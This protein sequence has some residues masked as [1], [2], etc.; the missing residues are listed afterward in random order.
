MGEVALL[1]EKFEKIAGIL[2]IN[3]LEDSIR[4]EVIDTVNIIQTEFRAD[5][6][7]NN[8]EATKNMIMKMDY[9]MTIC[10]DVKNDKISIMRATTDLRN[11]R[12][13][14]KS[15]D[16]FPRPNTLFGY[17]L[18]SG[19]LIMWQLQALFVTIMQFVTFLASKTTTIGS[20]MI[21]GAGTETYRR[22]LIGE[23]ATSSVGKII[24]L[25]KHITSIDSTSTISDIYNS[26]T[27]VISPRHLSESYNEIGKVFFDV[28]KDVL[29]NA[30]P[31]EPSIGWTIFNKIVDSA[32]VGVQSAKVL[33]Y[34]R[35]DDAFIA[36]LKGK[37]QATDIMITGAVYQIC[38]LTL[39]IIV[40]WLLYYI[41]NK[42]AYSRAQ[43]RMAERER[44][45]LTEADKRRY[46]GRVG[47][48]QGG[49]DLQMLKLYFSFQDKN[50][51]GVQ[52]KR[53]TSKRKVQ[54]KRKT[55]KRKTSKRKTSK[56]KVVS[57]HRR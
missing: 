55:S 7:I 10:S 53:A 8:Y 18:I 1:T 56:R 26:I 32:S 51:H 15:L 45:Y 4:Q 30:E 13:N 44:E 49:P 28:Q 5:G 35:S 19:S 9:V 46:F 3:Q 39:V 34:G 27:G 11:L 2:Y 36:E 42:I 14:R 6:L 54:S 43:S 24:L 29:K 37:I 21:G 57:K 52:S 50:N 38:I 47:I 12:L 40:L 25:Y 22:E 20:I 17:R 33:M 41:V 23:L 16:L 48:E 31:S